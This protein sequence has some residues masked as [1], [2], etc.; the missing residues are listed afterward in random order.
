MKYN[1]YTASSL[2]IFAQ[3]P[4]KFKY[5]K[6]DKIPVQSVETPALIKGKLVHLF[7]EHHELPLI[8][9]LK[10]VKKLKY[11]KR[12]LNPEDNSKSLITNDLIKESVKIYNNF[13]KTDLGK[14]ILSYKKLAVELPCALKIN[15]KK[16]EPSN[17]QDKDNIYRGY[18]DA[19]F[20]NEKTDEVYIIDWKT[21]ADKSKGDY[22]QSP[23]Q[24]MYYATWYFTNFP[25]DTIYIRYV[26]VE[27][28]TYLEFKMTR[29]RLKHYNAML[30][31]KVHEVENEEE[32]PK[33]HSALCD[34]CDFYEVCIKDK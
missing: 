16:L 8:D 1:P 10:Q 3:C 13:I 34:Y 7:L 12:Y 30:L 17:F 23:D 32:F 21:G 9:K 4:K 22:Q 14:Q 15:D 11:Q 24:L 18:I 19:C 5:A 25:V 28:G 27:H 6:I 29:D 20:V 26:F 2:G 31:K 33:V